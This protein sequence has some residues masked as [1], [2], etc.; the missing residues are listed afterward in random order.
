V[1]VCAPAAS[2]EFRYWQANSSSPSSYFRIRSSFSTVWPSVPA[3]FASK[4]REENVFYSGIGPALATALQTSWL[5]RVHLPVVVNVPFVAFILTVCTVADPAR[6]DR[7]FP[8]PLGRFLHFLVRLLA[9]FF[10]EVAEGI[11]C[12]GYEQIAVRGQQGDDLP[13]VPL[14]IW[15]ASSGLCNFVH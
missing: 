11:S 9:D 12:S 1:K 2:G 4:I 8:Y 5:G 10:V 7:V 15:P 3:V 13:I 14:Y 6:Q